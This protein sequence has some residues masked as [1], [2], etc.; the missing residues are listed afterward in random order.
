MDK[1]RYL[2]QSILEDLQT[3]MVFLGGPRQVGK[4][5]LSF[6]LLSHPELAE[7]HPDYYNWDNAEHRGK[8]LSGKI[9]AEGKLI[10]LDE[11]HKFADWRGLVK[12]L[13]D[14][15]KSKQKILVTGSARL[16]HYRKGGDSLQGRYHYYRLH[17]FTIGEVD[18]GAN[19]LNQ[20]MAFGGFPEPLLSGN[21]RDARR[22][23]RERLKRVFQED[24]RDLESVKEVT[25][26][27]LLLEH[28]RECV[29][30]PLS[31][32]NLKDLLQVS[33]DSV[34]SW[35]EIFNNL[36]LTYLINPYGPSKIRAVKKQ[37][38]L[39]FWDWA[40]VKNEGA[41]WENLVAS[42]LLKYC[43][44]T[45]DTLG[46]DMEL[47]Y[48]R[49]T[50]GREIDFVVLREGKPEFAVECKLSGKKAAK[51]IAYFRERTDIPS[52][53]IVHKD[54]DD[55]GIESG[56][57]GRTLPLSKLSEVLGLI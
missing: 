33:Y 15:R 20:L 1:K 35:I 11:I 51:N 42:H 40:L 17:P 37:R 47:R 55:Y 46:Y 3:K 30:S 5:T 27:E 4:T 48:L 2:Y 10:V 12:G 38:K 39:Y 29:G 28:L 16:D 7:Q 26:L 18:G 43:H 44:Y 21:E 19:S 49:D 52:F 36:Y 57:A 8:I 9:G 45:E 34:V 56:P 24:L 13:F 54:S 6:S 22:W 41:R 32:N 31:P 50:D 14:T 25:K 53:Y 23:Q